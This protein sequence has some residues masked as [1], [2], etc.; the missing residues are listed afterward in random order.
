ML[1]TA[2][3]LLVA[4]SA[5][6]VSPPPA[7]VFADVAVGAS[8][9]L[10]LES[11]GEPVVRHP[12]PDGG[13][14]YIYLAPGSALE[15][16]QVHGGNVT[17]VSVASAPWTD[18]LSGSPPAALGVSVRDPATKLANISADHFI[19]WAKSGDATLG[20]FR[21]Y[22]GLEYTFTEE[23]GE[24]TRIAARLP[25][26]VAQTLPAGKEP[27]L[28]RGTSFEDGIVL[29]SSLETLGVRS[30]YVYLAAHDCGQN[31]HWRSRG[32][33]LVTHEDT[34]YDV[35]T[36]TCTQGSEHRDFYFNIAGYFG[37]LH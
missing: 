7:A 34:P 5:A 36:A 21:G 31:G 35:L 11:V 16:V 13:N 25:I 8:A 9:R 6:I 29:K 17:A 14:E 4:Q 22:D 3:A 18:P 15:F 30:E 33:A 10:L 20:T 37:K 12:L 27:T 24:I 1:L 28:H 26:V 32:Q 19:G 23:H 2:V